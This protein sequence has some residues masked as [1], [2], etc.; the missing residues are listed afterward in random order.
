M[1]DPRQQKRLLALLLV[2]LAAALVWRFGQLRGDAPGDAAPG[3][4]A[5]AVDRRL[6]E[7]DLPRLDLEALRGM[8]AAYS[9]GR[10]PFR[11]GPAPAPPPPPPP[12][13]PVSR[14]PKLNVPSNQ[15]IVASTNPPRPVPPKIDFVYLGSF[16]PRERRIA[17]FSKDDEIYNAL[18]GDVLLNRFIVDKI[19]F[20]SADIKFVGF[21]DTPGT[22]L[23][24]G[25]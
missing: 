8:P 20:E 1:S 10:D 18:V 21:P 15:A 22:R 6:A 2:V 19:G 16:G 5:A 13:V 12:V 7:G 17:V 11:F 24:A 14:P 25:G 3:G 23:V 4:S 9:P